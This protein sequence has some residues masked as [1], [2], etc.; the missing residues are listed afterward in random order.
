MGTGLCAPASCGRAQLAWGVAVPVLLAV[1]GWLAVA[2]LRATRD[3]SVR[4]VQAGRL[5]L[6]AAG[7]MSLLS[8]AQSSAAVHHPIESSRYLSCLLISL[9]AVLWPLWTVARRV[10]DGGWRTV[11]GGAAAAALSG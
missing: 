8:Y 1:A 2:A 9:P 11:S 10:R 5:A 3:R 7:A 6:V 4:V